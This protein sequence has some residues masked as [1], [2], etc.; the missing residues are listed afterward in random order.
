MPPNAYDKMM[1]KVCPYCQTKLSFKER[2][3]KRKQERVICSHCK[4]TI[5][6]DII[7]IDGKKFNREKLQTR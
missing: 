4:E 1:R 3:E 5:P 7:V 2:Y 6:G